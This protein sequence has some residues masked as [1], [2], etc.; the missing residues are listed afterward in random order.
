MLHLRASDR[1]RSQKLEKSESKRRLYNLDVHS[2]KKTDISNAPISMT[3]NS[4]NNMSNLNTS[5]NL[6]NMKR[7]KTKEKRKLELVY[8]RNLFPI[9]VLIIFQ[10]FKD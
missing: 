3:S 9:Y 1:T 4:T 7:F 10:Y 5:T 8:L 6:N 2:N